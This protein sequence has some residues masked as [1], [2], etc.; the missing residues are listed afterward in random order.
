[1]SIQCSILLDPS[2]WMVSWVMSYFSSLARGTITTWSRAGSEARLSGF[3]PQLCHLYCITLHK[4]VNISMLRF[5]LQIW[6]KNSSHPTRCCESYSITNFKFQR[7]SKF[8]VRA[9]IIAI[10]IILEN[11]V[12]FSDLTWATLFPRV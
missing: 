11:S 4:L 7:C 1:M 12:N 6:D 9:I 8:Y 3:V 10:I 5:P 2:Y